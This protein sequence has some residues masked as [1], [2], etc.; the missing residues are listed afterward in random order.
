MESG[1]FLLESFATAAV[2]HGHMERGEVAEEISRILVGGH[3]AG[4]KWRAAQVSQNPDRGVGVQAFRP[5]GL[6]SL[7]SKFS[8]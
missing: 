4:A 7:T 1:A 5:S 8:R 6:G 3:R 2:K